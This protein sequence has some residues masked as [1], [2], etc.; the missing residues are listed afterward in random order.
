MDARTQELHD[1][2][3]RDPY[4]EVSVHPVEG[5]VTIVLSHRITM[6]AAVQVFVADGDVLFFD[7][8]EDQEALQDLNTRTA[9]WPR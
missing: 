2:C 3:Q 9:G 7:R 5:G 6:D 8:A 4:N 1:R